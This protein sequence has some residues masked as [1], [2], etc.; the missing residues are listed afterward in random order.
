MDNPVTKDNLGETIFSLSSASGRAG[1]AVFRLS[2]PASA[3]S[4]KHLTGRSVP[5]P[6]YAALRKLNSQQG[7]PID[8][9]LTLWFPGPASFTGEDCVEFHTHGSPAVINGLSAALLSLGLRQAEPGEFTRRAV[10]NGKM[11]LTEAEGLADLIDAQSEGQRVQALRQMGGGLRDLYEDW[12]ERLLDALAQIEGEIDFPDEGDIPDSLSHGAYAPLGALAS[13]MSTALEDMGRGAAIRS[14]LDIAII[15]APNAGKSTLINA[16]ARRE[17]AITS[18]EAGTTRDVVEVQMVIA[19][20]PVTLSD[21]AGLRESDNAIEAE[22][23]RRARQRA[24]EAEITIYVVR[25]GTTEFEPFLVESMTKTD[26]IFLNISEGY[27][28]FDLVNAPTSLRGNL[29]EPNGESGVHTRLEEIVRK[30]YSVGQDSGLTRVRH[31][32]CV[33]RAQEA[34]L[35]AQGQLGIAPELT[36]DD[37]RAAL[38]ALSE[39]AGES[40]IEAVFDRIFSR[41]CVGK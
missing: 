41:F 34:I 8:E 31:G 35:R 13:E 28:H 22:G 12:R 3:E 32:D 27:E 16:L 26:I 38:R 39:L 24:E 6:R 18:P 19:G 33:R 2:G 14:G 5:R 37:L 11:D 15:G 29:M 21:T 10:Q 17:I 1:V 20:L 9:A 4:V 40:D 30:H 25:P 23:V 7:D 36:G